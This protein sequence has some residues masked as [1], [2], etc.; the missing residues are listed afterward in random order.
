[1]RFAE[2]FGRETISFLCI[3]KSCVFVASLKCNYE[4]LRVWRQGQ[5][6]V[7]KVMLTASY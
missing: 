2:D 7:T 1:M 4:R 5:M 3:D 6:L